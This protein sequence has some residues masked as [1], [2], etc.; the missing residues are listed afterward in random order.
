MTKFKDVMLQRAIVAK[1]VFGNLSEK[2]PDNKLKSILGGYGTGTKDICLDLDFCSGVCFVICY[3]EFDVGT[4]ITPYG[5]L[6]GQCQL[7]WSECRCESPIY[8]DPCF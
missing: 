2:L 6:P 7:N 4:M 5:I 1:F 3:D 8:K